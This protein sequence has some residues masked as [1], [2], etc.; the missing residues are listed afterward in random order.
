M[1]H[2]FPLLAFAVVG[3]APLLTFDNPKEDAAIAKA[4]ILLVYAKTWSA[5]NEKKL[6]SLEPL[7]QY[8]EDGEKALIDPWG[9]MFHFCYVTEPE[10]Q[11]ERL[12][13][14]TTE[15]RTGKVIAAPRQL[16]HLVE[17]GN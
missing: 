8:A 16:A 9:Q 15:P 7:R 12:V 10:T 5:R 4:E 3:C 17:V 1:R 11:A 13:I 6:D 2:V 14:W